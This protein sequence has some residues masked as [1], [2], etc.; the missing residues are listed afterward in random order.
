M[1]VFYS[2]NSKI[3]QI[4]VL[5]KGNFCILGVILVYVKKCNGPESESEVHTYQECFK[6][7]YKR[8]VFLSFSS[9]MISQYPNK[10]KKSSIKFFKHLTFF[11]I[12][13]GTDFSFMH[14]RFINR[15]NQGGLWCKKELSCKKKEE[16]N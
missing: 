7:M 3:L 13:Y 10:L 5:I 15:W 11:L 2:L 8:S 6:K 14:T 9:T 4:K 1:P 16:K 12:K